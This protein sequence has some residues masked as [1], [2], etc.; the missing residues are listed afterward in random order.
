M[1]NYCKNYEAIFDIN[2]ISKYILI[3]LTI[4]LLSSCVTRN[5]ESQRPKK[6]PYEDNYDQILKQRGKIAPVVDGR[7]RLIS[8]GTSAEAAKKSYNSTT[9]VKPI[10]VQKVIA[11]KKTIIA[12]KKLAPVV[13]NTGTFIE[14]EEREAAKKLRTIKKAELINNNSTSKKNKATNPRTITPKKEFYQD[15]DTSY[16]KYIEVEI[17]EETEE[18]I[19]DDYYQDNDDSYTRYTR[20][21]LSRTNNNE[22]KAVNAKEEEYYPLYKYGEKGIIDRS[23]DDNT[24]GVYES[25]TTDNAVPFQDNEDD[26]YNDS[27]MYEY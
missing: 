1:N 3:V 13:N 11:P 27:F 23:G 25:F 16:T 21:I 2:K 22:Y 6:S 17:E 20:P 4:S 9:P 15:N 12:R 14:Q 8:L 18:A 19:D 7:G 10:K 24:R 26:F 5:A